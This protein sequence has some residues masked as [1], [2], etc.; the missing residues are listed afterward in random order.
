M[1]EP[2]KRN[3]DVSAKVIADIS[4][5]MY[6][7]PANALKEL[8]SNS[9]DADAKL[10]I[11]NTD[12]PK[13]N[14]FTCSDDGEGMDVTKFIKVMSSI[15]GSSK[16]IE[17]GDKTRSGR[18]K[19]GK[20]GI[21]LLA[22]TQICREFKIISSMG[23][24]KKFEAV[25]NLNQ[26]LKDDIYKKKLNSPDEKINIGEYYIY[27][28]L[29][30]E[31]DKSYTSII[32]ENMDDGFRKRLLEETSPDN[33]LPPE[34]FKL[35]KEDP[36]SFEKFIDWIRKHGKIRDLSEYNRM[37]WELSLLSPVR[38]V[39]SGP[40]KNEI[41]ITDIKKRLIDANFRVLV[42]GL[43]LKKPVLFPM[44]EEIKN[45]GDDYKIYKFS[46]DETKENKQL[47]IK[48]NPLKF[49]CY[50]YHQRI[51]INPPEYRG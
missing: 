26:F 31:R 21:G 46:Y 20:I 36:K 50:I 38:Y 51:R 15:G 35:I 4:I 25:I 23:N 37:L 47:M 9:W 10:V 19:I 41:V 8:V 12:Y 43:E 42:D 48:K 29:P 5:G 22:V 14:K 16:R 18:L 39:E 33:I 7:T 32:L 11:I 3:I 44:D 24:G 40:V 1:S 17:G 45:K 30:E 34:E 27:D 28:D 49:K 13:F 6:R 2:K